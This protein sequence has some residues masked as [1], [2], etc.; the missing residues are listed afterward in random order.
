M[1]TLAIENIG[2]MTVVECR[3]T[4]V[5]GDAA[6]ELRQAVTSQP[7]VRIVVIDLS[8]VRAI[9]GAALGT[10]WFLQRWSED[11]HIELKLYNPTTP[12]RDKL[13]HNN[14]MLRFEI[15]TWKEMLS[16]LADSAGGK[17]RAGRPRPDD[18]IP[19]GKV[20]EAQAPALSREPG[21]A[22]SSRQTP[23]C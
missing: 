18:Q 5:R 17:W 8:E 16:L 10:L 9:E 19:T 21:D 13:E 20:Y 15:A 4:I 3:G 6:V 1:L 11:H 14:S 7:D 2:D 12:V 23:M 22:T